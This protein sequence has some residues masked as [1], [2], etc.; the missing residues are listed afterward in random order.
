MRRRTGFGSTRPPTPST[1]FISQ[2]ATRTS[3]GIA[4]L[5]N[6]FASAS[7]VEKGRLDTG[8]VLKDCSDCPDMVVVE[9]SF[10]RMGAAPGD[11]DATSAELPRRTIMVP[12]R[13]AVGRTE[14]TVAQYTSFAMATGR[15]P[16]ACAAGKVIAATRAPIACINWHDA[17]AYVAW[18]SSTTGRTYRLP[19]EA[20]WEWAARGGSMPTPISVN[21]FGLASVHGGVAG[22]VAGCWSNTLHA[23]PGDATRPNRPRDCLAQVLRDAATGEPIALSRQSARRPITPDERRAHTGFRVLRKL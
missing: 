22:L 2:S 6:N 4:G 23:I 16:T 5:L 21:G 3:R 7:I 17:A 14:V 15:T 9:P 12:R 13:F 1:R 11:P 18:L 8:D 10:L 20:E 19:T